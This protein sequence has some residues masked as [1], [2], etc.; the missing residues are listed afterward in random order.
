VT[1]DAVGATIGRIHE[2]GSPVMPFYVCGVAH[3]P[4]GIEYEGI[5]D[6]GFSGF[7]QMPFEE[8]C[9]LRL[10]LEGTVANILAD[11]SIAPCLT[12]LGQVRIKAN[13]DELGPVV[14]TIQISGSSEIL[15]GMEFLRAFG[16]G[17]GVFSQAV[18]LLPDPL[19]QEEDPP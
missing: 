10:P 7:I 4:P 5:V 17:L 16:R 11:G 8:A 9:R 1:D 3:D 2:S 14:G 18:F 13:G 19:P 6:T 12:A 15:I